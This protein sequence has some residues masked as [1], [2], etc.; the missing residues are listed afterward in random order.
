VLVL[1]AAAISFVRGHE[2][3]DAMAR[4]SEHSEHGVSSPAD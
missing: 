4:S 1:V 3:R 2:D